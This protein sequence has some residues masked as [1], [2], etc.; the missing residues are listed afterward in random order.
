MALFIKK[1]LLNTDGGSR[2][3][4]GDSGIGFTLGVDDGRGIETICRGG[5]FIGRATNNCAEYKAL[6]WGL[7]NAAALGVRTLDIHADSE[8]MVKQIQGAYKVK[9]EGIKPLFAQ[10]KGLLGRFESYS[11]Q[12]VY[13]ER[14]SAADELANVAMDSKEPVG[15]YAIGFETGELFAPTQES[16]AQAQAPACRPA[17]PARSEGLTQTQEGEARGQIARFSPQERGSGMYQL[18]VKDHFDAAHALVGYPG[19]CKDLHGHTWDIEVSVRGTQ[20]DSVGIVYDFKDLKELLHELL[21]AYDHKYLNE[22]PPFDAINATAE[23]LARVLYDDLAARLPAGIELA[24]VSVWESPI[25][26][27]TY[28]R[29]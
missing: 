28:T 16:K 20:L 29:A 10:A 27:L 5:W 21:D 11:I 14:N 8:L 9:N 13:R 12:H 6:I 22:V 19:Q 23:N 4:P 24:E 25:A 1:A 18:T 2:G 15:D 26:K 7:Q 17:Q 3:N